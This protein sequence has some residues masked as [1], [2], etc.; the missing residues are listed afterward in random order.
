[1][2]TKNGCGKPGSPMWNLIPI[3]FALLL[4]ILCVASFAVPARAQEAGENAPEDGIEFHPDRMYNLETLGEELFSGEPEM[5]EIFNQIA[6]DVIEGSDSYISK[7]NLAAALLTFGMVDLSRQLYG[8][9]VKDFEKVG[10]TDTI[11]IEK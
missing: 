4:A 8:E 1:M 7:G 5:I 10:K 2:L 3:V 11:L 6:P 9:L